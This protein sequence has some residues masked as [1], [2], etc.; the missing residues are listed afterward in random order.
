M[1][2]TQPITSSFHSFPCICN[3]LFCFNTSKSQVKIEKLISP[4]VRCLTRGGQRAAKGRPRGPKFGPMSLP[5][6]VCTN[7]AKNCLQISHLRACE[8]TQHELR[9][10]QINL[11]SALSLVDSGQ[12]H[13]R[14]SSI[15]G[16]P[17]RAA[18]TLRRCT[19]T[20]K[21]CGR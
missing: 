4:Q 8:A 11:G 16:T 10:P 7:T 12:G 15:T 20:C 19:S 6:D 17:Y 2:S 14:E 3:V 9:S 1:V 13:I 21:W 18:A 5:F